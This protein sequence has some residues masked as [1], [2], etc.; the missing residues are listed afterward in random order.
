MNLSLDAVCAEILA[1]PLIKEFKIWDEGYGTNFSSK[2]L[3]LIHIE[4]S[5][6]NI[7]N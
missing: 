7:N 6:G 1:A 4:R 3:V 2:A 5:L